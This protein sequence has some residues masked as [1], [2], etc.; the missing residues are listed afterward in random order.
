V[1]H[2]G[3]VID[4]PARSGQGRYQGVCSHYLAQ[5]PAGSAV[6]GFVRPPSTP[7]L[8]PEDPSTPM[9][10]VAAG[11][12][13][14]PFRGFLQERAAVK[15]QG[16]Q[17]VGSSALFF[18]CRNPQQDYIYEEELEEYAREGLTK[19]EC[20]FSR[21]EGQPKVYVQ[22]SLKAHRNDVWNLIEEGAVIYLC[23]DASRMAPEV[24]QAFV[25]LYQDKAGV[26]EQDAQTWM[27]G[28][29]SSRRYLVDVW[30]RNS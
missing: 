15:A 3:R 20:A 1:Q 27:G 22:N 4:A 7:F 8:P 30:P 12:G 9:I 5:Q 21:L 23:G 13:L 11:T 25:A 19:L 18:G 28:L 26:S 24:E 10:M 16:E 2:H 17:E 29:K 6:E 14:A